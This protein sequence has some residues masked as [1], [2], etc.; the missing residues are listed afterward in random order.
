MKEEYARSLLSKTKQDYT[1]IAKDFSR[2]RKNPWPE[3]QPL[4][5]NYLE[6]G[7]KV[8]DLGCGNGRYFPFFRK[9]RVSYFGVDNNPALLEIAKKKF[10]GET[11]QEENA[12]NLSFP[13]EFFNK[14]YSIAVLH[15]IPSREFRIQFIKE[16][17]RVLKPA[18][19]L[20]LTVWHFHRKEQ[21]KMMLKY[22]FRKIMGRTKLDWGDVFVPWSER[23]DRY[24]HIF[25]QWGLER[26]VGSMGL[27][28]MEGGI[29]KNKKGTRQ[30]LFVVARKPL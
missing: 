14:V 16:A 8:L 28:V 13:N 24:Y 12:L 1:L 23:T 2:T 11:F 19:L 26:L 20:V 3:L 21:I 25:S 9:N 4:F 10:P 22:F 29:I 30:N 15:Q 6:S 18:G 5:D 27:R 7:D 17:E